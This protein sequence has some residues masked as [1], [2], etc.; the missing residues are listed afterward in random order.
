MIY[1][2]NDCSGVGSDIVLNI[3]WYGNGW[4]I[5]LLC[6]WYIVIWLDVV[7]IT[8]WYDVD[9]ILNGFKVMVQ[10]WFIY[11]VYRCSIYVVYMV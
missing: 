2:N 1:D 7:L 10:I 9:V 6:G 11:G 5:I 8:I 3:I 4:W